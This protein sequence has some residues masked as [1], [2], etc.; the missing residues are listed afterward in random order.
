MTNTD[1]TF[2]DYDLPHAHDSR[3]WWNHEQARWI[4]PS[5]RSPAVDV[6]DMLVV[7]TALLR[8]FRLAPMA[9]TRTATD[10][11]KQIARVCEHLRLLC[12]LLH[13]H[14]H[15]EDTLLWPKLQARVPTT[16]A[17]VFDDIAAQHEELD[18]TVSDVRARLETWTTDPPAGDALA[19]ALTR[20]H[21][22]LRD[23][24]DLEERAVLP[25]AAMAVTE[26]E[27]QAVGEAAVAALPKS[28]LPLT[29]GMFAYE[30]DPAVLAG[31]LRAAPL[32]PR[33][34]LPKIAPRVYARRARRVHGTATP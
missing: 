10:D 6:R 19:D 15:G 21:D 2:T 5:D 18:Q 28:L 3:C 9:V 12:D 16:V 17:G 23:H 26:Q 25:L 34:V 30:G 8:E 29:F 13:H 22:L 24:L 20:L 1:L 32:V 4:C 33:K 14:H 11:R 31:M 7:H 27:W